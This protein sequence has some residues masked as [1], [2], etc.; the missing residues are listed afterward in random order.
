[1]K[2]KRMKLEDCTNNNEDKKKKKKIPV[3]KLGGGLKGLLFLKILTYIHIHTTETLD[4]TCQTQPHCLTFFFFFLWFIYN[5][6]RSISILIQFLKDS[7]SLQNLMN[8][9]CVVFKC[10]RIRRKYKFVLSYLPQKHFLTISYGSCHPWSRFWNYVIFSF[11]GFIAKYMAHRNLIIGWFVE[12][13][14][15]NKLL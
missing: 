14:T 5:T 1:M 2:W 4:K 3:L 6:D 9:A 11:S 15:V 13:C 7:L 12:K 8:K 10:L